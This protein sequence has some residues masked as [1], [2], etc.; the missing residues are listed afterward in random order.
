VKDLK[1]FII[2][3]VRMFQAPFLACAEKV[4]E[5]S[6]YPKEYMMA[7]NGDGGLRHFKK[8][9]AFVYESFITLLD[10][11]DAWSDMD[12]GIGLPEW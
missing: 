9:W 11:V 4:E 6:N 3:C 2:R 7:F 12:I 5:Y 10:K 8:E 1:D